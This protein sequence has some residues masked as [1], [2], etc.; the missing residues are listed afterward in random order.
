MVEKHATLVPYHH[1]NDS[2][3]RYTTTAVTGRSAVTAGAVS[4]VLAKYTVGA[5]NV[6]E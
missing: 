4:I 3:V 1:H 6:I 5:L 2:G